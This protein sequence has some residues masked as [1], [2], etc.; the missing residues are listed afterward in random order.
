MIRSRSVVFVAVGLAVAA[1]LAVGLASAKSA[2]AFPSKQKDCSA[3]HGP[4][5]GSYRGTVT[6]TPSSAIVAT[7]AS[8]TIA[9]T[10]SENPNGTYDT[11]YWVANSDAGGTTG[12]S[13]GVYGGA[14][15]TNQQSYTA[16]MTAPATP[17][18][19]YYKVFG[20][21][22]Q[23]NNQ[24]QTNFAVYAITVIT[25]VHDVGV[26]A[27]R[28][29]KHLWVG[30]SN[31]VSAT[32]VNLG[33]QSETFNATLAITD[34]DGIALAPVTKSVTVAAGASTTVSYG[35]LTYFTKAGAYTF[36]VSTSLA[37]DSNAVNNSMTS[38]AYAV[39]R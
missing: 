20:E 30:S 37:G 4:S 15:G 38:G 5:L 39:T 13:T 7:G 28:T 36:T 31:Y 34:P 11:G 33:T 24:G 6:A 9:I 25:P 26:I 14:G 16:T 29:P 10:I 32:F 18:T 2:T 3:C 23:D 35:P 17:G 8:Y 21:D 22:G 12:S 27:V 19:Y 1:T